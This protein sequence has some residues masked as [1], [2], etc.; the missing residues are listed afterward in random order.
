MLG[1]RRHGPKIFPP[2]QT[3]G[4]IRYVDFLGRL[5]D[6][7]AMTHSCAPRTSDEYAQRV[8]ADC[9]FRSPESGFKRPLVSPCLAIGYSQFPLR[10]DSHGK[11]EAPSF[12]SCTVGWPVRIAFKKEG[13]PPSRFF[14]GISPSFDNAA[15]DSDSMR[16]LIDIGPLFLFVIRPWLDFWAISFL[17]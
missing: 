7:R 11:V 3:P 10:R 16:R 14:F 9:G 12:S 8:L 17:V 15:R 1:R 4:D 13:G 6:A 5:S 2:S